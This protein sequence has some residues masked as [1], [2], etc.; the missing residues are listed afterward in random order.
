MYN[1][2]KKTWFIPPE[3]KHKEIP[4]LTLGNF[5][6]SS[7]S[8]YSNEHAQGFFH[9]GKYYLILQEEKEEN[10]GC[11]R[12]KLRSLKWIFS[13]STNYQRVNPFALERGRINLNFEGSFMNFSWL[14]QSYAL[15]NKKFNFWN[16]SK[17]VKI[18]L[19]NF[20]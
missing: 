2:S 20:Y 17:T 10:T 12:N 5:S 7:S 16:C 3:F 9:T 14:D 4:A 18:D 8:S 6:V 11:P 13:S 1:S 15:M 19:L